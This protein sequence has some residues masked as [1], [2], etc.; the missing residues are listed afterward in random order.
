M[1]TPER[2]KTAVYDDSAE[3]AVTTKT[4]LLRATQSS[5]RS[6]ILNDYFLR[7]VTIMRRVRTA[8]R[9]APNMPTADVSR[10]PD[11]VSVRR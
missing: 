8:S 5:D 1:S 10:F 11:R 9:I 3:L 7:S 2:L 4:K 6:G